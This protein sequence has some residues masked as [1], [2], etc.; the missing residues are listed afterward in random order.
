MALTPEQIQTLK[1]QLLKK[2]AE[3][4]EKLVAILNGKQVRIED[5]LGGQRGESKEEKLRRWLNLIDKK[6]KAVAAG[7]YGTCEACGKDLDFVGLEQV[8]WAE[9]CP[10]CA[11][12][13]TA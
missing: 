11:A 12:K 1:R 9:V 10:E 7:T 6:I 4:N 5:L 2:G 3:V 13:Q 8:P